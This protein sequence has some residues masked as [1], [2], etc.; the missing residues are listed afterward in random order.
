M[1]WLKDFTRRIL[2][3]CA[4]IIAITALISLGEH[5]KP[6]PK[7]PATQPTQAQELREADQAWQRVYGHISDQ[8]KMAGV[9]LEPIEGE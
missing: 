1:A 6:A 8:D 2:I 4:L 3:C 5:N 7:R 9:V